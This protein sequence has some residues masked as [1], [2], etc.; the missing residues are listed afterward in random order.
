MLC[1]EGLAIILKGVFQKWFLTEKICWQ[2]PMTPTKQ[3]LRICYENVQF[4][5]K[6]AKIKEGL[7]NQ[8]LE[9][10]S[11]SKRV[12]TNSHKNKK[13]H[14]KTSFENFNEST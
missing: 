8:H 10:L 14:S 1:W 4:F 5:L 11:L 2:Q 3:F 12:K 9:T 6:N 13:K 7:D